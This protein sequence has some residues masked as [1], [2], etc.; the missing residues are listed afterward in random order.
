MDT[1]VQ[2]VFLYLGNHHK[3]VLLLFSAAWPNRYFVNFSTDVRPFL[4]DLGVWELVKEKIMFSFCHTDF[5]PL[6]TI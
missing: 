6:N 4:K 1:K 3:P 2:D 5:H